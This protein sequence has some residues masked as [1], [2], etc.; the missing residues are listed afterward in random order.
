MKT[1]TY[2]NSSST[3][4]RSKRKVSYDIFDG[5][6]VKEIIDHIVVMCAFPS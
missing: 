3:I 2:S 4:E 1:K 6:D 5:A